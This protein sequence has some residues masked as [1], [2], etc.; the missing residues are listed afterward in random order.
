M[1]KETYQLQVSKFRTQA[2]KYLSNINFATKPEEV[3]RLAESCKESVLNM[4][5]AKKTLLGEENSDG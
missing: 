1:S 5:L 2:E 4:A 3:M